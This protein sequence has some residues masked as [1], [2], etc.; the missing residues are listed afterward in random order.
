[1]RPWQRN[2][3]MAACGLAA[4]G[5]FLWI[6]LTRVD[7]AEVVRQAAAIDARGL[8]A[9]AALYWL[10]LALRVLRWQ[11]LLRQLC[12]APLLTVSE[13]LVVGYAVN[14]VLP[15]RLGEVVR[16]AYAKRRLG[17]GRARGFG[18]IVVE[19]LL[20]LA[21]VLACL[22]GGLA[23]LHAA[24]AG[25]RV[26]AFEMVALNAGAVVG[27]AILA[28]AILR[29]GS[30]GRVP[31]PRPVAQVMADFRAGVR[32]LNRAT[33]VLAT[34]LTVLVWMFE[35]FALAAAF[36][37]AGITLNYAQALLVMGA[38]SLSTL[39]PTAPG[40]LG[41]YQLVAVLAMAAFGLSESAGIVAASAIQLALFGSVTLVGSAILA[42]R[43]LRHLA[44]GEAIFARG[45]TS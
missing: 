27:V 23:L 14:N 28:I 3:L 42:A 12:A 31:L 34:L 22:L 25:T 5:L 38:A 41:T 10:A 36:A 39:V 2:T 9:A 11:V 4:G 40:Y 16:A 37:A 15:A 32:S 29:S 1:M 6:A 19:R 17:V 21:A 18:S 26:P 30:L 44:H 24:T 20:D 7:L 35:T 45:E 33:V 13:T 8:A 43:A